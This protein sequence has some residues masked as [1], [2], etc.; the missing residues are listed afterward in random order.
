MLREYEITT[1]AKL[2]AT[3]ALDGIVPEGVTALIIGSKVNGPSKT[4]HVAWESDQATPIDSMD[5]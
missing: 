4:W 2:S 5:Q 1:G 3:E